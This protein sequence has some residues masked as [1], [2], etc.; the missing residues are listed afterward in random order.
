MISDLAFLALAVWIAA[1]SYKTRYFIIAMILVAEFCILIGIDMVWI[2]SS[3]DGGEWMVVLKG[4]VY[5]AFYLLYLS[6]RSMYLALLASIGAFYHF[7]IHLWGV[8]AYSTVMTIFC[9]LQL[10]GAYIG[11]NYEPICRRFPFANWHNY[12]HTSH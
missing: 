9:I 7:T 2:N 8:E 10:T 12:T 5:L 6:A 1:I 11:A 4:Y 3:L